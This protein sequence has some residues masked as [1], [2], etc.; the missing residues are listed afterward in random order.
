M[1]TAILF[2]SLFSSQAFA[3]LNYQPIAVCGDRALVID[4]AQETYVVDRTGRTETRTYYQLVLK[5]Q[6]IIRDFIGRGAI[7]PVEVNGK[8]EFIVSLVQE[9]FSNT[10]FYGIRAGN[11]TTIKLQNGSKIELKTFSSPSYGSN[12]L[13]NFN[14]TDCRFL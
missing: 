13:A 7:N 4:R 1:K 9:T 12:E 11:I 3:Q 14:F 8:G 6:E 5:N 10:Q 2:L